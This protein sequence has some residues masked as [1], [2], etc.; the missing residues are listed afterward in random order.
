MSSA[1]ANVLHRW[2][3]ELWNQGNIEIIEKL[4]SPDAIGHGQI[5]QVRKNQHGTVSRAFFSVCVRHF[6][7]FDSPS[8]KLSRTLKW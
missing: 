4:A 6:P 3:E 7:I 2:F 8:N 5:E 1:N